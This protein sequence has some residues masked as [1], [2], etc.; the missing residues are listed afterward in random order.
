MTEADWASSDAPEAMLRSLLGVSS[1]RERLRAWLPWP[2]HR[3]AQQRPQRP[4]ERKLRLYGCACCRAIWELLRNE[5]SRQAVE[6]S[7]RYADGEADM[8]ALNAAGAEAWLVADGLVPTAAREIITVAGGGGFMV[9]KVW[10]WAAR[11]A[12]ESTTLD[13]AAAALAT[14]AAVERAGLEWVPEGA[15]VRRVAACVG[16]RVRAGWLRDIVGNPFRTPR[17]EPPGGRRTLRPWPRR[18][19]MSVP[20]TVCPSWPTPSKKLAATTPTS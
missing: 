5:K 16:A 4:S 19:T 18:S 11:A 12:A 2:A 14:D 13:A 7:E 17:F 8:E 10:P 9:G 6:T 1:T 3:A 20:S 15:D